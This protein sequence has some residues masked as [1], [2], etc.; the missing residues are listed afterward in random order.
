MKYP[1]DD[2]MK[3]ALKTAE[4]PPEELNQR[5]LR[6]AEKMRKRKTFSGRNL[7]AAAGIFM[8]FFIPVGTYA[9]NKIST[10]F[11][12][13]EK[14]KYHTQVHLKKSL[15]E[16]EGEEK[17]GREYI[18]IL[19]DFGTEYRLDEEGISYT[20]DADGNVE[21]EYPEISEGTN[22]RYAY[23]HQDGFDA[24]QDFYY[25]IIYVDGSRD[26]VLGLYD[27][28]A[29]KITINGHEALLC[30]K[31]TVKNSQYASDYDTEYTL[32][33]YV[34]YE[35]YGYMIHYCGMQGLG[36]KKLVSL[37]EKVEVTETKKSKAD[38]YILLSNYLANPAEVMV[39][40]EET[41]DKR[42]VMD[43]VC[44]MEDVVVHDT[45]S[46]QV[47]SAE[48]S[49]K[50]P[51]TNLVYFNPCVENME[52]LWNRNGFLKTY[53]RESIKYGDGI[54]KPE[55]QV[56]E[57]REIQPKMVSVT[58]KVT[59]SGE[60]GYFE[61]PELC[62]FEKD[63]DQYYNNDAYWQS[64]RPKKI[65]QAFNDFEPCYFKE[66]KGGG[67][68]LLCKMKPNQERIYHFGYLVDEDLTDRMYL[69]IDNNMA[70]DEER[71]YIELYCG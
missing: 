54:L 57:V 12:Q 36:E 33:L 16:K 65:K 37:A 19:A 17:A 58:M 39:E 35:E 51:D 64:N 13:V 18:H 1:Y 30:E 22:G 60:G 21:K 47:L 5:I 61:L 63:G 48:V 46:Y 67:D 34:F 66:T 24:G 62:F 6:E 45:F 43:K 68:F 23:S 14:Q 28:S 10:Y 44:S 32:N 53:E 42:K 41:A 31:N 49:S 55:Q 7:A 25:D 52:Q 8:V 9:A 20:K 40:K 4:K 27:T 3:K 50:V 38:R 59:S 2:S 69:C 56:Q 11:M 71:Q 29:R 15:Y 70:E 26:A